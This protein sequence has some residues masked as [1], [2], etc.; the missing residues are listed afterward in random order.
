[1]AKAAALKAY[2]AAITKEL[3]TGEELLAGAS[4][5]PRNERPRSEIH[6][7]PNHLVECGVLGR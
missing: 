2:R 3:A 5:T 7:T 4:A 1:M 6:E